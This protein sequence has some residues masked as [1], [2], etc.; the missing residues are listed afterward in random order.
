MRFICTETSDAD[1][2]WHSTDTD[3]DEADDNY[4][5]KEEWEAGPD[6]IRGPSAQPCGQNAALIH[7]ISSSD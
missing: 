5:Y 4:V 3:S 7:V 6:T 2:L 1:E